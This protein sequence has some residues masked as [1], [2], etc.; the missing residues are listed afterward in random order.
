MTCYRCFLPDLAGFAGSNCTAPL[1]LISGVFL[2]KLSLAERGTG[3]SGSSRDVDRIRS[4][5]QGTFQIVIARIRSTSF[6][7]P[8]FAESGESGIR[9]HGGVSPTHAFQACSL[10]HSDISPKPFDSTTKKSHFNRAI[11]SGRGGSSGNLARSSVSAWM[12]PSMSKPVALPEPACRF[13][14]DLPS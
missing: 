11:R 1:C 14:I 9:T 13:R 7:L 8:E 10:N 2:R 5:E 4:R 6:E 3:N 12:R